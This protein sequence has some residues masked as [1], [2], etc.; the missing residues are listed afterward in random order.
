MQGG[1]RPKQP[2]Q[3]AKTHT[4]PSCPFLVAKPFLEGRTATERPGSTLGT[5]PVDMPTPL[6]AWGSVCF[7]YRTNYTYFPC[8]ILVISGEKIFSDQNPPLVPMRAVSVPVAVVYVLSNSP[9]EHT[10]NAALKNDILR[11]LRPNDRKKC[12]RCHLDTLCN[13]R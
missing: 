9:W 3:R 11:L 5:C 4:R 12:P 13:F 8:I 6:W 1:S 10:R 2:L 7:A